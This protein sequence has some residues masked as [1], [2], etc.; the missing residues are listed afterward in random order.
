MV[1]FCAVIR[2][3][4][5]SLNW[6]ARANGLPGVARTPIANTEDASRSFTIL[7]DRQLREASYL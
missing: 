1:C 5:L 6:G 3:T 2:K 4:P 7:L